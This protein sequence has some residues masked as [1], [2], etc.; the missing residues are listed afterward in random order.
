MTDDPY[1][2]IV[3]GGGPAGLS[4]AL[5]LG[6][7]RRSVLVLDAGEP[8]NAA[9][10]HVHNYLGR[11]GT[12]PAELLAA[13]RAELAPYDVT[14]LTDRVST[15]TGAAPSLVV[16]TEGGRAVPARR[17]VLATGVS[18]DLPDL[19]GLAARWGR[20]V[21]HCPYCHGWEVRDRAVA[22]LASGPMAAHQALLFR[23]LTD[24]V[25]VVPAPGAAPLADADLEQVTARGVRV[26]HEAATEVVVEDDRLVGLL[27]TSGEVLRCDVVVVASVPRVRA[28][29]LADLGLVPEPVEHGGHLLATRLATGPTGLTAVPGVFAAGNVAEPM[30][31]VVSSAAAGLMAGAQVNADLVAEEARTAV[32]SERAS[33]FERPAWEERYA[34]RDAV[35]SGQVNAQLAAEAAG[36]A[37]GRALDV[38]SG[39]GGD[40]LWLAARGW[41][42]TGLEFSAVARERAAA[43]AAAAGLTGRTTWRDADLR[44]WDP[45]AERWDLVTS[46]FFHQPDGGMVDVVRRLAEAVAVGGTLLVVGHHPADHDHQGVR[47]GSPGFLHRA[48]DLVV[49]LDPNAWEIEVLDARPRTA[50]HPDPDRAHEGDLTVTDAVLRARRRA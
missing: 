32:A 13:G 1:D 40:A 8:R 12:P 22:V 15:V 28:G 45:G 16:H 7:S 29:F 2:V 47:H 9:A 24:D 6:R 48:E 35:W 5:V 20:D 38:G 41:E 43:H 36:L 42:V 4:A 50:P 17:L 25:V 3:V 19:P 21:L 37:P 44:D 39:E 26:L 10:G 30:A 49:A 18:D 46:H 11:E 14:V 27:L 33:L 34:A 31:Q 23:Q